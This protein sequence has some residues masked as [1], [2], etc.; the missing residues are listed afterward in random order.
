MKIYL[1]VFVH[2]TAAV[3]ALDKVKAERRLISFHFAKDVKK[4]QIDM[5]LRGDPIDKSTRR[6]KA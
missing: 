4:E 6:K 3:R 2:D 5:F 1:A